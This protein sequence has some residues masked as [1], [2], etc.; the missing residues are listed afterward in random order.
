MPTPI[1]IGFSTV[2]RV[3][4]N[5]IAT[6]IELIKA[7]IRNALLVPIRSV[8]GYP[9]YGSVIP[10]LPFELDSPN[11]GIID[12]LIQNAKNQIAN[13]PRVRLDNI[14]VDNDT[15]GHSITL[16]IVLFFI[17]FNMT[18]ALTLNFSTEN[19]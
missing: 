2:D 9:R 11:G 14:S 4:I 13:D 1:Y 15:V 5:T 3:G 7:D 18:N 6:N 17:E 8:V 16:T 19:R 10:L 12:A